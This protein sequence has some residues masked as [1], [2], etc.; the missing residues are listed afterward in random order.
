[1]ED[2][3]LLSGDQEIYRHR[4]LLVGTLHSS[5]SHGPFKV[6]SAMLLGLAAESARGVSLPEVGALSAIGPISIILIEHRG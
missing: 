4:L 2:C 5:V 1:M 6:V 3:V